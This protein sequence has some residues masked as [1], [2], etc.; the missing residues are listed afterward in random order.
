MLKITPSRIAARTL[1]IAPLAAVDDPA[2]VER[3]EAGLGGVALGLPPRL[4][5]RRAI[6]TV[7]RNQVCPVHSQALRARPQHQI[8]RRPPPFPQ[9][10]AASLDGHN[11]Y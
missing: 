2:E 5:V 3:A 11:F 10:S 9:A 4:S 1:G 8:P 6:R 7:P